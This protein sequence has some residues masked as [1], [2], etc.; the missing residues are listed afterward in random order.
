MATQT[1]VSQF[2]NQLPFK[3]IMWQNCDVTNSDGP[4]NTAITKI[5]TSN[6][7]DTMFF[8][9]NS[10]WSNQD[11]LALALVVQQKHKRLHKDAFHKLSFDNQPSFNTQMWENYNV[12]D[13]TKNELITLFWGQTHT[14]TNTQKHT[15]RHTQLQQYW[16][17]SWRYTQLQQY[18]WQSIKT[19]ITSA[20]LW[21]VFDD[22]LFRQT[23]L[24]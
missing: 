1:C 7:I 16:W 17:Q 6:S 18:W 12:N 15:Q 3:T 23:S 13:S 2:H 10:C 22:N 11:Q 5:T 20:N 21:A 9:V 8:T 19:A 14:H 24:Q 4:F